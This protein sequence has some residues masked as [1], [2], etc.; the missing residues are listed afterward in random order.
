MGKGGERVRALMLGAG[1][2]G[3]REWG[4]L[5]RRKGARET[6]DARCEEEAAGSRVESG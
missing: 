3:A 2:L 4:S 6:R 1:V 5:T